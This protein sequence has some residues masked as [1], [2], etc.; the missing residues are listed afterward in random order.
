M[1]KCVCRLH[2]L[3]HPVGKWKVPIWAFQ[4]F[5]EFYDG[6]RSPSSGDWRLV[7]ANYSRGTSPSVGQ[8]QEW[9]GIVG[10]KSY[11]GSGFGYEETT[12]W[13]DCLATYGSL[14]Y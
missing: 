5:Y 11:E 12:H 9:L 2:I 7:H 10:E 13:D 3:S 4:A 1:C 8:L 14:T 6:K